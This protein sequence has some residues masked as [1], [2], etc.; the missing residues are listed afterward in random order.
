MSSRMYHLTRCLF[1]CYDNCMSLEG[2]YNPFI[3]WYEFG[4]EEGNAS[5]SKAFE[6]FSKPTVWTLQRAIT[7]IDINFNLERLIFPLK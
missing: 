2:T 3:P 7:N 6:S 1:L 5:L 4:K